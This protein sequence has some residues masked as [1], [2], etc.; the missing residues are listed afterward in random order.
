M[1]NRFSYKE[2]E[3]EIVTPRSK[4]NEQKFFENKRFKKL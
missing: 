4:S 3:D 1:K 2:G